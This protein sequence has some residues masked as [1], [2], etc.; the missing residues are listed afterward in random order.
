MPYMRSEKLIFV[1]G[2]SDVPID[3]QSGF[4]GIKIEGYVSGNVSL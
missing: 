4:L 1:K 2:I 3:G